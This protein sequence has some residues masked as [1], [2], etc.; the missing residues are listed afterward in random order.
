MAIA[1]Y[2]VAPLANA[3]DCGGVKDDAQRLACYD[4]NAGHKV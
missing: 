1:L 4:N 2:S 3:A